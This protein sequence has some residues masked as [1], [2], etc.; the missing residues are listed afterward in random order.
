MPRRRLLL[1]GAGVAG[2]G[3]LGLAGWELA[4]GSVKARL[5]LLPDPFIPDAAEGVVT[6]T[7]V[8][9]VFMGQDIDLF[10]AVPA[11]YGDGSGLP[12]VVILH[13]ASASAAALQDFGLARFLTAAVKGGAQPIVLAGTDDGPTGWL[14]DGTAADPQA[15]LLEELPQWLAEAGSAA[16]RR[17]LWGWSRGGY[18]AIRFAEIAPD[19]TRAVALF[20][21]ALGDDDV[22]AE[23]V[24][25]L[26]D[27]PLGVWCGNDDPFVDAVQDFVDDLPAEPEVIVFEA[28]AH[29]RAFWNDHTLDAFTWLASHL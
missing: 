14:A 27:V 23:G 15:M 20:S 26:V 1:G 5:R 29:T 11:G 16:D 4:P 8:T 13:G 25:G 2:V 28:G 18:G 17:A 6:L 19:W 7:K 3:L 10:T 22:G 9:S 24:E 12:A 21:P